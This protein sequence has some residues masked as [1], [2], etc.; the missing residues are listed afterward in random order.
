M[1]TNLEQIKDTVNKQRDELKNTYNVSNVGIF[2]SV[3][4]EK[5]QTKAT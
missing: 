3:A 5:I 4:E 1:I 2:G